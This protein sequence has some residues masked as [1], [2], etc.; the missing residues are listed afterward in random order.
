MND[1]IIIAIYAVL[2]VFII[3]T[4]VVSWLKNSIRELA[5]AYLLLSLCILGWLLTAILFYLLTDH[6]AAAYVENVP[7]VFIA[8]SP[9][10]LLVF[11]VRF[12]GSKTHLTLKHIALLS[13]LPL[14]TS[15]I[16][17][18]PQLS[19]M[20]R[21]DYR[22]LQISPLHM[23]SYN[24]NFWFFIHAAYSYILMIASS[25]FVIRQHRKQRKNFLL[26]STLMVA[27]IFVTMLCNILTLSMPLP[28]GD[29]TLVGMSCSIVIFYY[30]I[31]NNPKVEYLALARKTLYSHI[32]MP[33][34]ILDG[35]EQV[36]DVN[37]AAAAFLKNIKYSAPS[38]F[39]FDDILRAIKTFGGTVEAGYSAGT[40]L[41]LFIPVGGKTVVYTLTQRD[42]EDKK[43]NAI[44]R[45]ILMLDITQ[46]STMIDEL[47]YMADID[48]LTGI[49]NRRAFDEKCTELDIP[50]HLP[51]SFIVGD[52]NRLKY[53]NDNMGHRKGDEL[54]KVIAGVLTRV[55]PDD[56][57]TARIG[58]DEF[59]MVLPGYDAPRAKKLMDEIDALVKTEARPFA[60]A[61][62]ALGVITKT[63]P[64]QIISD[65]INTADRE[66]YRQKR[67][68]RRGNAPDGEDTAEQ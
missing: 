64:G 45:Y 5:M 54:L 48:P 60:Q 21:A 31:A 3:T 40:D 49:A 50:G 39:P 15:C 36:L 8:F 17:L 57:L 30:A 13:I 46:L 63:Q 10:L 24:W 33:V 59:I 1:A 20:L 35:Y 37:L 16:V 55:C 6:S 58:G 19:W 22:I 44:G 23:T 28:T 42:V 14:A 9:V 67:Y 53:V 32:G 27:G 38:P 2:A 25:V 7:F 18:F 43:G 41:N 56:G 52:V 61:S 65:L 51:L 68:D 29:Y 26:P 47:E 11:V 4:T 62:I 34:L 12:Y 66:M